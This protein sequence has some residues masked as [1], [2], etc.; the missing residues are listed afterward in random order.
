MGVAS[1]MGRI[2]SISAPFMKNLTATSGLTLV[3][4]LYGTL[5]C[6]GAVLGL[7]LPE[8]KGREIPDTI[9]EAE[10]VDS[11][12]LNNIKDKQNENNGKS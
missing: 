11:I 7:F 12:Q 10:N 6:V 3:M 5:T 9:E 4:T 2:G 8:T 1:V